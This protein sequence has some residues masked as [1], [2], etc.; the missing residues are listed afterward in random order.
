MLASHVVLLLGSLSLISIA[1]GGE[2]D[3]HLAGTPLVDCQDTSISIT[4]TT[5][6]PFTGRVYVKGLQE[7]D[8]CSRSYAANN[9]QRKFTIMVNQGD[10]SMQRQRVSG[11]SLEGIMFSMVIV[12]SFHGTF[13]TM[14][15]K[16]YRSVCFFRNIKR[17]TNFLD[18]SMLPTAELMDTGKMPECQYTIHK[19]SSSG[20]LVRYAEIGDH[21]FHVWECEDD[22]QGML[23]H[24]CWVSDGRG[25]RFELLDIDGCAIDPVIQPDVRYEASLT[26]A[27][28]ETWAYKYSDT[29]VLDYQCVVEL[30]KKAQGEC[31]GV[32]PPNCVRTKRSS[33]QPSANQVILRANDRIRRSVQHNP[34]HQ[35][36]VTADIRV[37]ETL[38]EQIGLGNLPE[39]LMNKLNKPLA[40]C[41]VQEKV[42][43]YCLS[44]PAVGFLLAL[45]SGLFVTTVAS[46]ALMAIRR[47]EDKRKGTP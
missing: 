46:S 29:S 16:A 12:V 9:D 21:L 4:F 17:V 20:P 35:I 26:K 34:D 44:L 24:S 41:P 28:V 1:R 47:S 39:Q 23:V 36:D 45:I 25:S 19:D 31:E 42:E 27:W 7:D 11:G 3:N 5:A 15:D 13:E 22:G 10:C 6:K 37:L 30:C 38:D 14:N 8:R 32:T 40:Q 43:S 18:V 2:V 33:I